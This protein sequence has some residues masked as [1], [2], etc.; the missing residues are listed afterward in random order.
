MS[1]QQYARIM[2]PAVE[3]ELKRQVRRLAGSETA[4]FRKMLAFHMGWESKPRRSGKRIRPLLTLLTCE[5]V[6]GQW[7]RALPAAAALELVHNFSLVHDDIEDNS[8]TRRNRPTLWR[9]V[10][11]PLAINAGDALFTLAN[12]AAIDLIQEYEPA[13]VITV[14][15]I[16]EQACLDLTKGQFLDLHNQESDR[17]TPRSYWQMIGGKTAALLAASTQVGAILGGA[18]PRTVYHYRKFGET[19]GLAFQVEDDILGIWGDESRTGKSAASDLEEG[20]LSLPV[21]HGLSMRGAF[22]ELWKDGAHRRKNARRLRKLLEQGGSLEYSQRHAE[23][24]TR[25]A[26]A[27]L[28]KLRSRGD[29]GIALEQLASQLLSRR[30]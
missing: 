23:R 3:V 24:L 25:S 21:V 27:S 7:R 11:I 1:L 16:L 10:G 8:P 17:L 9:Q 4:P 12:Q 19:L 28:S 29:A 14:I 18:G 22:A 20:K 30:G 6:G 2:L 5:S 13:V 15:G 26:I